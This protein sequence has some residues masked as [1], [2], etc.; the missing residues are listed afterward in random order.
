MC[1]EAR[2]AL[3]VRERA[4]ALASPPVPIEMRCF[5]VSLSC[6]PRRD[7][8][9]EFSLRSELIDV[10]PRRELEEVHGRVPVHLH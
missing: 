6:V 8:A 9:E 5:L 3:L 7:S 10:H 4:G 2:V 1:A